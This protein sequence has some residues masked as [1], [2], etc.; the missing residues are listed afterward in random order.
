MK[1]DVEGNVYCTAPGGICVH[2]TS[3]KVLARIKT[4]GHHPTNIAWGD[5]DWRSLYITMIGSVVRTRL[6]IAGVPSPLGESIGGDNCSALRKIGSDM[7]WKFEKVA[8]PCKG[9]DRRSGVGRKGDAVQR[10]AG[11]AHPALRPGDRQGGRLSQVH[12]PHQR[13]RH[14]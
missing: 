4:P 2:D 10:G 12:R 6:N 13:P 5:D 11:R 9:T 8:G 14:R 7:A 1:C 3:G